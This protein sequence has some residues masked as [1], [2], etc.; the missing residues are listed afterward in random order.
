MHWCRNVMSITFCFIIIKMMLLSIFR[1]ICEDLGCGG[2]KPGEL[3]TLRHPK[4]GNVML[5][6]DN[7]AI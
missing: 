1:F 5:I 6:I 3:L 2:N 7:I 4:S